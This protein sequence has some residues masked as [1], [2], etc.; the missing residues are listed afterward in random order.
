MRRPAGERRERPPRLFE[1][2]DNT[3]K[4]PG[5]RLAS[6]LTVAAAWL[7]VGSWA[8]SAWAQGNDAEVHIDQM[9]PPSAGS[10]FTRAEGPHD[11]FEEGIAYA[12]RVAGDYSLAPLQ[13]AKL[14]DGE[15]TDD[16]PLEPVAHAMLVHVGAALAPLHWL[17]LELNWPF[18]VWETGEG[19]DRVRGKEIPAGTGGVGD[20]RIG[21]HIRPHAS[22]SFDLSLGM[23]VWAPFGSP[24]AYMNGNDSIVRFEAVPAI[25]GEVDFF[26]YGCTM[27]IAPLFF[28]GQD[29]SRVA[30]SC[31]GQFKLAPMVSIGLEPHVAVFSYSSAQDVSSSSGY[32]LGLGASDIAVQVEPLAALALRFDEWGIGLAG[33]PGFG[34]APGTGKARA[35]LSISY[36]SRGERIVEEGVKDAD[37]DGVPDEYDA[38]PDE[39]GSEDR[40]GCPSKQDADGDG[41]IEGDACPDEQGGKYDD[42]AANGCPDRDN[43]RLADPV[44]PCPTEPGID[45]DGCPKY[46]RLKDGE[47]VIDPPI[48][49]QR[50]RDDLTTEGEEALIEVI[51]TMR[52]NPKIEQISVSIGTRRTSQ[53]IT[54]KR[55]AAIL[56]LFDLQ[57]V[58]TTRFEV[59]LGDGQ[60][61]GTVTVRIVR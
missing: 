37:L 50:G 53:R 38:C 60:E 10:P 21:V 7:V 44:D 14:E 15:A 28:A 29:G 25:A 49:F 57:N 22:K 39:A 19:D 30:A 59:V 17:N 43:D 61:G 56:A 5:V 40:R 54:D 42:P 6:C 55:A 47:F 12:F 45:S 20:L 3:A 33:G 26:L 52:A 4:V 46:A 35:F 41:I 32:T 11:R 34:N 58:E 1:P 2:G 27:G 36:A 16:D 23:R 13:T 9:Q 8:A 48:R 18:A 31:A 51:R 24:D